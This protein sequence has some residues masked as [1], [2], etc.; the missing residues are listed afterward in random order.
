L[1]NRGDPVLKDLAALVGAIR[2]DVQTRYGIWL[3][4]EPTQVGG[5]LA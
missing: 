3:E 4:I 5:V 2:D 1:V